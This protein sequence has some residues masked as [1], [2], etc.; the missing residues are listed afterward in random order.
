MVDCLCDICQCFQQTETHKSRPIRGPHVKLNDR[1][2]LWERYIGTV[3][4]LGTVQFRYKASIYLVGLQLD[5]PISV[6]SISCY[7]LYCSETRR[8]LV[9]PMFLKLLAPGFRGAPVTKGLR[10]TPNGPTIRKNRMLFKAR[11]PFIYYLRF[12]T[13]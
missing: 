9:P 8:I 13:R 4:Y 5:C 11:D 12:G 2:K 6:S 3:K 1:V 10:T 7:R